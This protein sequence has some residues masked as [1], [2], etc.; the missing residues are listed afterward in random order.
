MR[1]L[2][3]PALLRLSL[4]SSAIAA[5]M[6]FDDYWNA[7]THSPGAVTKDYPHATVITDK[8]N[9]TVYI[10]TKPN[11]PA[12]PGVIVRRLVNEKDGAY[13]ETEGHSFGPDSAQPAFQ[14]WMDN[15]F[16]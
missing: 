12:H 4:G 3:L 14:A 5:E 16:N 15:P 11:S 1:T 13:M 8:K 9:L 10:F 6:S 7:A 2:I